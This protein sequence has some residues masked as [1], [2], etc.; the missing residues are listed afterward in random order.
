MAEGNSDG[1]FSRGTSS[2]SKVKYLACAR[3]C[4]RLP[5]GRKDPLCSSCCKI[6]AETTSQAQEL[7][8]LAQ[9]EEPR[10]GPP[11]VETQ[12]AQP[13]VAA[14]NQEPPSWAVS[15]STG[16][17]KL[18]ACLDKLLDKLD[19]EDPDPRTKSLK[20][21]V[22]PHTE[23]Y[24]DS[25]S[26]QPSAT[27]D[28]QSLSE[29]EISDEDDLA[30]TEETSKTPSEAVDSLIAAVISCLDLKTPE[31]QTSAQSLFKRQKKLLS[32]FPTHEQ[33]D[34]IIQSEWDHPEKRFQANRRFQRS[35]PFPQEALHKWSTPPSVDAPI[36]R[37]SKNTALPVPDSS[38]FKDSM[39]KKTEGFLRA[40]YTASGESLRPVLAS[41]WVARAIQTWSTSLIDG[42]NSGAPRQELAT[43]ASQ[44]KDA[45]EYL[46]EA[47][48]D[49]VQAISRTSAL[50]VAARRSLWLKLWSADLS[51]KKSLTTIPF[52]GK[53]LFG[54]ELDKII[55][56]ATGGKS[57]LL[58]Q[59]RNR[60]SFRRGRF[61]RTRPSKAPPSRDYQSQNSSKPRFQGRPKYSWQNKKP[62]A[63]TSDK[64]STA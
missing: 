53:L 22:P 33:L 20:R 30:D 56:Q 28:E 32:M 34:S 5:S 57:T 12:A 27:W 49:A 41:A 64:S 8:P 45:N 15:L 46:C 21:Q 36:S 25:D 13:Q 16:I 51:S 63:K 9:T 17:P 4:K 52:K 55:S 6:P 38:S 43:L 23:E 7:T 40:A 10:D 2:A 37:L 14:S 44:I 60:T 39:D 48:L 62:Q 29:G 59:P 35:Y 47:S 50:S 11:P 19:R 31:A 58:P 42:I 54:P 3:C 26:P 61:F 24:S 1:P 18:A